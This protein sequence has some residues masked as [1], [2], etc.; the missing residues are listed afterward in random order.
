MANSVGNLRDV[1]QASDAVSSMDFW[2]IP[3]LAVAIPIAAATQTLPNVIVDVLPATAT[4]IRAIAIFKARSIS[5]AGAANKL[6]GAQEIQIQKGGA[7]GFVDAINFVV[8]EFKIAA[9]AVDAP[10]DVIIGAINVVAKVTGNDTYNFQWTDAVADVAALTFND[11]QMG[12]RVW[13]TL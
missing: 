6:T 1:L 3:Q 9:A 2:S 7:G 12:I 10:A 5:N 8:D 13:F 11:V 4:V